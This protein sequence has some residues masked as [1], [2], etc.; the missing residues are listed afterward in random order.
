[1]WPIFTDTKRNT[2]DPNYLWEDRAN[3]VCSASKTYHREIPCEHTRS[4]VWILQERC[5]T[6]GAT[7]WRIMPKAQVSV[8][9]LIEAATFKAGTTLLL[10]IANCSHRPLPSSTLHI[11]LKSHIN[12]KQG[13]HTQIAQFSNFDPMTNYMVTSVYPKSCNIWRWESMV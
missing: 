6:N 1:M 13:K 3:A 11:T 10:H 9:Q 4:A 2:L 12:T 5:N 7:A 8:L